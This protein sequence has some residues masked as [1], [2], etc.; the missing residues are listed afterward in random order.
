MKRLFAILIFLSMLATAQ[1]KIVIFTMPVKGGDSDV[2]YAFWLYPPAANQKYYRHPAPAAPSGGLATAQ[3][4]TDFQAGVFIEE[5]NSFQV[6]NGWTNAQTRTELENRYNA[7][8]VTFQAEQAQ[9]NKFGSTWNGTVWS[10]R[11]LAAPRPIDRGVQHVKPIP[12]LKPKHQPK[13]PKA[14][15]DLANNY[16]ESQ[17]NH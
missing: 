8:D 17:V 15:G 5:L 12:L 4:I 7:R 2:H 6:P 9:W 13:L 1:T 16:V 3:E 14:A 11:V 10:T